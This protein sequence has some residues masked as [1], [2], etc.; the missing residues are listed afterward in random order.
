MNFRVAFKN[1]YLNHAIDD[2]RLAGKDFSYS[3]YF[4]YN[5]LHF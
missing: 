5:F 2:Y 3:T 4:L 1:G